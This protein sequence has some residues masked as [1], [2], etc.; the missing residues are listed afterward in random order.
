M[1]I[2][3]HYI[4]KEII[5]TF[6]ATLIVLLAILL[7]QRLALMLNEV[8]S[9]GISPNVILSMIGIQILRFLAELVPLSFLLASIVAFGRLYK[10]SEMTAMFALGMPLSTLYRLLF[11]LAIPLSII[12]LL[13]NFFLIPH[14]SSRFQDIQQQAREEAQL[15]I[16]KAGTFKELSHGKNTVYVREIS[17]DQQSIKDVFIK[18][19]GH[20]GEYSI[21]L[22]KS[23]RQQIEPQSGTRFLILND[24]KRYTFAPSGAVDVLEYRE[25]ILR[26]DGT[27]EEA[28]PKMAALPTSEVYFFINYIVVYKM[29][30][31][32]RFST[33]ISLLILVIMIPAL[34]HSGPRQGRFSNLLAG[35]F[36]YV[37]YFNLLN[38][39]QTWM[40]KGITPPV[41]GLW[42]VHAVMLT[43]ALVIAYRFSKRM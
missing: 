15:T 3:R 1:R 10:D 7:V 41:I 40:R 37:I 5:F 33:A 8:M 31:E 43:I 24:G 27:A 19:L 22:A 36:I 12:L 28:V 23:G 13:L 39:A 34:A 9:G 4:S 25:I 20:E 29:E 30:L 18:T 17:E 21:T 16:I 42:W 26:L 32:R 35:I 2:I 6:S 38:L 14:F 11:Q